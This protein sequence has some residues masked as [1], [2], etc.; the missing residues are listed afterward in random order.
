[1][2]A[3]PLEDLLRLTPHRLVRGD[4]SAEIAAVV[5]DSRRVIP[6]AC[7]VAIRGERADGHDYVAR[8]IASGAAA[9]AVQADSRRIWEPAV[10]DSG[11]AVIE[12]DDARAALADLAAAWHGFPAE[13]L[14]VIG[15]TGTDGKSTTTYLPTRSSKPPVIAAA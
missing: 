1:M 11:A 13:R 7:F 9:V 2:P 3:R 10:A 14:A 6:G 8:A 12:V 5:Q 15:V 4:P